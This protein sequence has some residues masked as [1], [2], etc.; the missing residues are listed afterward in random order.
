MC[1]YSASEGSASDWHMIHL[2]NLALS[3]AGLLM[4]EATAV[5]AEGRITLNDLG[6][7][8]DENERALDR[9]LKACRTYSQGIAVG[10]QLAHSGRKGS[11]H[12][13]WHGGGPL[14]SSEG[15]WITRAP[16]PISRDPATWPAPHEMTLAEIEAL[17]NDYVHA[18]KRAERLGIDLI[19]LHMAHGY[20]LH[21]FMSPISNHRTDHYGGSLENRMRL[22]LEIVTSVRS[23]WPTT[24][25]MGARI[26]GND[27]MPDGITIE[28]AATFTERLK[29]AGLDYVCI[30]SGGI[31]PITNMPS[32]TNYQIAL[33]EHVKKK[34]SGITIQTVGR[35]TSPQ[36][37]EEIISSGK[38][39]M[40]AIARAF[41]DDPRWVWHAARQLD[42]DIPYPLQYERVRPAIWP[43]NLTKPHHENRCFGI[44]RQRR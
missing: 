13:P 12:V 22:P 2:G 7:Y 8:S 3:G 40:V 34:T 15:A 39:D 30:S 37:A 32:D 18:A 17:K 25:P 43:G 44:H 9:V 21:E 1:Q 33:A 35:I 26:T 24:K 5:N 38:A 31:I 29:T 11:A 41:L 16:S 19:E 10:I 4:I 23:Q 6:L 14:K 42:V 36:Q 27:W 28:D 20:L